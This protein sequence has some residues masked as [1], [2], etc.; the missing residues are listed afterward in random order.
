MFIIDNRRFDKLTY[1]CDSDGCEVCGRLS[2]N[3]NFNKDEMGM[4]FYFQALSKDKA[5]MFCG[6]ECSNKWYTKNKSLI[7]NRKT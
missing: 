6:C 4:P 1:I 5:V 2:D 7:W 3:P